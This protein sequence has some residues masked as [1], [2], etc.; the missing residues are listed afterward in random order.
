MSNTSLAVVVILLG[1]CVVLVMTNPTSKDYGAFLQAQLELAV[2]R[3]DPSLSEQERMLIHGLY[4]SQGP[5]LIE[6]VLQ[7]HTNR[8]NFG[9]FSL[10]ESHVLGQKVVVVGVASK[11]IPLEGVDEITVKVGQLVPA[12]RK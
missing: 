12:L 3:M 1:C 10:F 9:F 8:R 7:N 11:F 6:M 5:K 2:G 4:A